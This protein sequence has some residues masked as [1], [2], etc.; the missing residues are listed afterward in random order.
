MFEVTSATDAEM[1]DIIDEVVYIWGVTPDPD[2]R[3][4]VPESG[5]TLS[6]PGVAYYRPETCDVF[7]SDH[8]RIVEFVASLPYGA[9]LVIP[10]MEGATRKGED[11]WVCTKEGWVRNPE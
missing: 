3:P 4:Y 7:E 9:E 1:A 8:E 6:V 5:R 10:T 2:T 11:R